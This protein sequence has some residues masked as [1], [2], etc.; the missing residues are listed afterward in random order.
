MKVAERDGLSQVK[1]MRRERLLDA[2]QRVFQRGGFRGASMEAIA[3]EGHV[4]KA[5]LYGYF[6]D[7]EAAFRAVAGR[8]AEAL[9]DDFVRALSAD[10]PLTERVVAALC[11]KHYSVFSAVRRFAEAPDLL[12][13]QA[14]L[15]SPDFDRAGAAMMAELD[16]V[17]NL[18]GYTDTPTLAA[19]MF[20][21]TQGL[22]GARTS[23][24]IEADIGFLVSAMLAASDRAASRD[25]T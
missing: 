18:A 5:T 20:A 7:K 16:E 8:I 3:R 9:R 12:A 1:L 19:R 6:P 21:A 23:E 25:G 17:L 13:A 11:G 14:R 22:A 24:Q 15:A 4:A 2:A 10:R